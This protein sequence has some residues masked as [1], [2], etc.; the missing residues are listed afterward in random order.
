MIQMP[1]LQNNQGLV[2]PHDTTLPLLEPPLDWEPP[3]LHFGNLPSL[4]FDF[5]L[6]LDKPEVIPGLGDTSFQDNSGL[7]QLPESLLFFGLGVGRNGG[8]TEGHT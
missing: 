2:N 1:D 7:T 4:A 5:P 3:P 8:K 6:L